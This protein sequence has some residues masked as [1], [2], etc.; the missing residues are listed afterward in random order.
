MAKK[1][2]AVVLA[3]AFLLAFGTVAS[4]S[5]R[6]PNCAYVCE[7]PEGNC[8]HRCDIVCSPCLCGP[9]ATCGDECDCGEGGPCVCPRPQSR[10]IWRTI[11]TVLLGILAGIAVIAVL[12][13]GTRG[14][15]TC[16]FC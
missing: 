10:N 6:S 4:A 7:C 8:E 1:L 14:V 2:L 12:F 13:F 9:D 15:M 3:L 16:I 11:L 5:D